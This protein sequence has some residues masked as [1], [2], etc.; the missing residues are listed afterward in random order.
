M[1]HQTPF[2][3]R[4]VIGCLPKWNG[5]L[6]LHRPP[7]P[8]ARPEP[9]PTRVVVV[10]GGIA[11]LAAATAV[12][13]ERPRRRGRGARGG[14]RRP[15]ASSRWPRSAA[16]PWTSVPS[17]C[18]TGGPRRSAWRGAAGLERPAGAPRHH[19]RATSGPAAACTGCRGRSWASRSTPRTSPTRGI[20]SPQGWPARPWTASCPRPTSDGDD[21]SVGW[22]IEERFGREVLDRLV[23]PLLGGVY[24]GHAREISARAA[25]AA[26]R[27]AARRATGP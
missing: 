1:T 19:L 8:S 24:A 23:E 9:E 25:A 13:R 3:F 2:R 11:G 12:R 17:R 27:R 14:V 15:A 7:D 6:P 5:E 21:V 20:L 26:G 18:S 16:S 4:S 10:G 22:L